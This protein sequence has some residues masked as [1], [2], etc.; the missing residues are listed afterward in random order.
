MLICC[1]LVRDHNLTLVNLPAK[2]LGVLA[3]N[4]AT[5]GESSAKDLLQARD[6]SSGVSRGS[7]SATSM[8]LRSMP[9]KYQ[10]SDLMNIDKKSAIYFRMGFAQSLTFTPPARDLDMDLCCIWRAMSMISSSE[11]FPECFTC[12]TFLRSR[13]GSLSAFTCAR[14]EFFSSPDLR[15]RTHVP[16]GSRAPTSRLFIDV[17]VNFTC[18]KMHRYH[19]ESI[20]FGHIRGSGF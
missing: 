9:Q 10:L 8:A 6:R 7:G 5:H 11:T 3:V 2:V 20:N 1:L 14:G 18:E 4:S 12:L 13:S 16:T 15:A 19:G 17:S